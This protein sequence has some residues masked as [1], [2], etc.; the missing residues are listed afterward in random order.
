MIGRERILA[1]VPHQGAMCLWDEVVDWDATRIRVRA[2]THRD[3]AHP[4]RGDGQLR[5]V[6][7]CEY[8]AQAMAVHGGLRAQARGGAARAGV[9]VALRGVA[10]HV[11]R[12]DDLPGD[13]E[14]EAQPL[15][16]AADSQQYAFRITH[17]GTL[18]AEGRAAVV[19][20]GDT[21]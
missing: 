11:A 6:H 8:G 13:L 1:L 2:R 17:A 7:L 5:G 3:P 20:Q 16:E 12:I 14:C 19:L 18:I 9:L 21:P 4:L 15:A 10:V